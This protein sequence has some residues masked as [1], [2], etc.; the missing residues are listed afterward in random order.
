MDYLKPNVDLYGVPFTTDSY[1]G[2]PYRPLGQSGLRTANVGLGV[3]KFGYPQTGDE[4]RVDEPTA[5]KIFDRAVELGATFW[6]T[7]NRYN[8]ASGNSERVIGNWFKANPDQRRNVVLG[9]KVFGGMDGLT[10]NH[11]GLSRGNILDSV[12]ACLGRL[13]LQ[14]IDLL[15]FHACDAHTPV[16]ESLSAVEDLIRRGL[17]RYF[18][19]SNFTVQQ[20]QKY[21]AAEQFFSPRARVL[22]VQNRFDLLNGEEAPKPG[23][24]EY[25]RQNGISFVA[26]GPLGQGLLTDRYLDPTKPGKGDRLVDEGRLGEATGGDKI[27]V[28]KPLAGLGRQWGLELSQLVIAYML[29]LEGMGPIIAGVSSVKQIQSN[30]AAGKIKLTAEQ[31]AEVKKVLKATERRAGD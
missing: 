28:L 16:E 19:V 6:D 20:L 24:L 10:P 17:V 13:Q 5:F 27:E 30:A 25:A 18:A 11:S 7:A 22:A 12:Y 23:V 26:W 3:W 31:I 4:S 29:T 2:M 9:T 14:Y 15:Y 21:R 1:Q 8:N